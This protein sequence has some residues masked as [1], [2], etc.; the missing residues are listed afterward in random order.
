MSVAAAPFEAQAARRS[1]SGLRSRAATSYRVSSTDLEKALGLATAPR[2]A[3]APL[4]VHLL[5]LLGNHRQ[6][7]AQALVLDDRGLVNLPQFI[8]RPI[9]QAQPIVA[10]LKAA[11][12][13]VA[14]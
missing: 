4:H 8:E 13:E 11:V 9:R 10:N 3:I 6:D 12:W 1:W 5:L 7:R 14:D 2:S